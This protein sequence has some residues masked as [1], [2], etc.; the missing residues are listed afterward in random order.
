MAVSV[1]NLVSGGII[2]TY[3][4]RPALLAKVV[5]RWAGIRTD[6]DNVSARAT[7]LVGAA[8]EA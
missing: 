4:D 3:G 2:Q 7:A 6:L 5:P 8:R 1:V